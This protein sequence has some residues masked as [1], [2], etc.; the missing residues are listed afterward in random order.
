MT[1]KENP[2]T[3]KD[4]CVKTG[5]KYYQVYHYTITDQLPFIHK[6]SGKG[7]ET[8]YEP[9]AIRILQDLLTQKQDH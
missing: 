6:S 1:T 5:A 3:R 7:D 8:I 4:L 9:E 2:I